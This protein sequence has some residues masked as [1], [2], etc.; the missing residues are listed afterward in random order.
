MRKLSEATRSLSS[1]DLDARVGPAVGKRHD[2][3]SDLANDFDFM[4]E[5]VGSLVMTQRQLLSDISHELRSPLARLNVALGLARQ[6]AGENAGEALDRIEREAERLNE[7]IGQLLVLAQLEA[8]TGEHESTFV[9]MARLISEVVAD[10][11][12]EARSRGRSVSVVASEPMTLSANESLLRSAVENVVRN[13]ARY[14]AEGTK[15]EVSLARRVSDEGAVAAVV[16]VRDHGPGV[17]PEALD[18]LFRP[19]Y[20]VADARDRKTGGTGLGLAISERAV[21]WH[22]GSLTAEN[23]EDGGLLVEIRL[24]LPDPK[25]A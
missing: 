12:F 20:R 4:A 8:D 17:P 25:K 19:F 16:S 5:R 22:A 6:R 15:V 13:A 2:E 24:P 21:R 7:L 14:T 1:G 11:D 3:L 18:D 10:A 23:V 9:D